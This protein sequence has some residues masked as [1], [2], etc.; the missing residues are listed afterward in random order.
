MQHGVLTVTGKGSTEIPLHSW[1]RNIIVRFLPLPDPVPCDHHH[2]HHHDEQHHHG[3]HGHHGR[4]ENRDHLTYRIEHEDVKS[5]GHGHIQSHGS[6]HHAER[7]FF[8][9]INWK[10]DGVREI[11]WYVVY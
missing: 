8:L 4:P 10:V 5:H 2:H 6:G 11:S 3:H 1:P 7:N 9:E